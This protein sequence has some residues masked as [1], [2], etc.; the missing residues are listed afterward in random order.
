MFYKLPASPFFFGFGF[1][2][3]HG[4]FFGFGFWVSA[5]AAVLDRFSAPAVQ[6]S[7]PPSGFWR[8]QDQAFGWLPFPHCYLTN[9]I[10]PIYL[11]IERH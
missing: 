10:P 11:E 5:D 4:G 7:N 2:V 6:D 1:G 8:L 9:L 3:H